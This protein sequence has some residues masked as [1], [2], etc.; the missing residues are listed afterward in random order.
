[1]NWKGKKGTL[2]GVSVKCKDG[3]LHPYGGQLSINS[4]S[5]PFEALRRIHA[6]LLF[7][8]RSL[9][10]ILVRT[11]HSRGT[12]KRDEYVAESGVRHEAEAWRSCL[13]GRSQ[14]RPL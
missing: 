13:M 3:T 14:Q 7:D 6:A 1:M 12:P 2:T 4:R 11:L 9:L 8:C 5:D 10:S